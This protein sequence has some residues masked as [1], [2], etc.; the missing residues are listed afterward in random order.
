LTRSKKPRHPNAS[1]G[2]RHPRKRPPTSYQPKPGTLLQY[3]NYSLLRILSILN[4]AG[5]DGITTLMLLDE[6]GS[7]ANRIN[8]IIAAAEQLKLIER[9]EGE[10]PS[11]GQ[12][13]PIFNAITDKGRRLLQEQ[14]L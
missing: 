14:L 12:F 10:Q 6:L 13:T 2:R 3:G 4:N 8:D 1:T 9:I 5:E 7:R 11:P